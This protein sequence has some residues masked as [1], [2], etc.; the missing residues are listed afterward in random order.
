MKHTTPLPLRAS[1]AH[2]AQWANHVQVAKDFE[3]RHIP[4]VTCDIR[5]ILAIGQELEILRSQIEF[6]RAQRLETP[7]LDGKTDG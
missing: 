7:A 6:L 3:R 4:T 5:V 2:L 1:P